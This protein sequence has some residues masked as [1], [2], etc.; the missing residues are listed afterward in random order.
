MLEPIAPGLKDRNVIAQGDA[1]G[2]RSIC[3]ME[4]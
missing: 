2:Y 4:P 3:E 1:L